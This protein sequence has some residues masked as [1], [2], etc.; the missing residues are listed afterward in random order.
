MNSQSK[1]VC[2]V[3]DLNAGQMKQFSVEGTDILLIN[4]DGQF[5]ATGAYCSHYGAPLETGILYCDK[6]ATR[7][8]CPWHN[9]CFSATIGKMLAPPG[10]DNLATFPVEIK[11]D[12]VYVE[13]PNKPCQHEPPEMAA[14]SEADTRQFIIVGGGAG[15]SAAAEMIRQVGFQGKITILTQ[16]TELPYDRTKLSK[17]HLQSDGKQSEVQELRSQ[18]FYQQ[19]HIDIYTGVKITKL[20][21]NACQIHDSAGKTYCYDSLLLATG[22]RVHQLKIPGS[23]LKNIYTLRQA[24]DA[25]NLV[26]AAQKVQKVV[27]VGAGF[28]G[29]EAAAS[30]T[31]RGLEVTVVAPSLPFEKVLGKQVGKLFQNLH[32]ENGVT[33]YCGS[34]V[35]KIHGKDQVSAVELDSGE[36]L[37]TDMIL[38]GIGVDPATDWL[39]SSLDLTDA[40][41]VSVNQYLQAADNVYAVGDIASFPERTTGKPVRIEHW[42]LALQQGQTAACNMAGHAIPFRA[43]PF[44]WTGQYDIKLRYVGHAETWNSIHIDGSLEQKKFLAFYL[45]DDRIAAVAG[46]GCD[47]DIAA[48]SELMRLDQMPTANKLQ[49]QIDWTAYLNTDRLFR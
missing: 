23:D 46:I 9:A 24:N 29:M 35:V 22:G 39:K 10:R 2:Q 7:V 43:V 38:V 36:Q 45:Q 31:Q 12:M 33:F 32:E 37:E 16:E 13:L 21:T 44:F 20:D 4:I 18:S 26:A 49:Q 6:S 42:R 30:L 47:R 3:A 11:D 41:A 1:V 48:I 15:G 40:G 5:L 17:A 19:H 25:A 28:I 14:Y 27:V 8:I 34:K